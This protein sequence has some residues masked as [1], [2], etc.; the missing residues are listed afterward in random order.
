MLLFDLCSD[1]VIMKFCFVFKKHLKTSL[2]N[3]NDQ[4]LE[5]VFL[6]KKAFNKFCQNCSVHLHFPLVFLCSSVPI[7]RI[8]SFSLSRLAGKCVQAP[9]ISGVPQFLC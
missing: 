2:V 7:M 6:K 8:V 3:R 5:I 1:F 4:G 9:N